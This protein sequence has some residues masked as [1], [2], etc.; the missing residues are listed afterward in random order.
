MFPESNLNLPTQGEGHTK[1]TQWMQGVNM[2][3]GGGSVV[4]DLQGVTQAINRGATTVHDT[5]GIN[6]LNEMGLN[7]STIDTIHQ[8]AQLGRQGSVPRQLSADRVV[9]NTEN[10]LGV[11]GAQRTNMGPMA[12]GMM[13]GEPVAATGVTRG[14]DQIATGH[15]TNAPLVGL[16]ALAAQ[17]NSPIIEDDEGGSSVSVQC[18]NKKLKSGMLAKPSDN[19]KSVEIWPHFSLQYAYAASPVRFEDMTFEQLVAGELKTIISCTDVI[20]IR[21]RLELLFRITHLKIKG[22]MGEVLR[23]FYAAVVR[24]IEQYEKTWASDMKPIEEFC[25]DP[26][27]RIKTR[28]S[29]AK[30]GASRKGEEWFCKAFNRTEGC[31][32]SPPHEAMVG[33][34]PRSRMVKHFCAKCWIHDQTVK[35]HSEVDPNCPHRN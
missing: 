4:P 15:T 18:K 24:A 30:G 22:Y 34:P 5:S 25:I 16:G 10:S 21:G 27:D 26:A 29:A 31:T 19:I 9:I 3:R 7:P 33:R 32:L 28:V 17:N 23:S 1:V 14:L 20:E 12:T 8:H 13:V 2:A 6:V 11:S 35:G